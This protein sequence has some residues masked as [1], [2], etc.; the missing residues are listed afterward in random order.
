MK[1]LYVF[2]F[3]LIASTFSACFKDLDT[4]PLDP[5]ITTSGNAFKDEAVY[6]QFL[7]KLY[8]GLAVSGQEGP[9]GEP[10]IQGIDEGFGQYLRGYWYHQELPTDEALIGWNDQTIYNFHDLD[11]TA[12]DGFTFA[13]YSRVFYQIVVCNEFLRETTDAK[14]NERNVSA[15]VRA[16]IVDYIAEARFLRALSYWHA[17][18]VFRNVP[19]VTENDKVGAFFPNQTNATDLFKY[20]ESELLDIENTIKAPRTNQYGRADR[21]AV[22]TL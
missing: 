1:K 11:W 2:I 10:D 8:A 20:I 13:F 7:G 14:L 16:E 12:S 9:A 6:K 18:D 15:P 5:N 3:I 21:A 22:W 4:V 19:F 17:L